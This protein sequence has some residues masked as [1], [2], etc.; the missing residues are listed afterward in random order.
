MLARVMAG[1]PGERVDPATTTT[2]FEALIIWLPTV[3]IGVKPREM[4]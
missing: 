4:V 2:P 1:P 3:A